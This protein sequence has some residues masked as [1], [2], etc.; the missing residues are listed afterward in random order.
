MSATDDGQESRS[1]K[2]KR[3]SGTIERE[4]GADVILICG[5]IEEDSAT[6]LEHE[7]SNECVNENVVV[8]L[9]TMGGSPDAAYRMTRNIQ[10][11]YK[12]GT[13]TLFVHSY[14]KSA[15]TLIA[16]GADEII[17]SNGAQLGPLDV[18]VAKPDELAEFTSG[19]TPKEAL[20]T[21]ESHAYQTFERFF[22]NLQVRSSGRITT[23]TAAE[24]ATNLAAGLF[25]PVYEQLDPMRLGEIERTNQIGYQ[26]GSRVETENVKKDTVGQLIA[27]YPSHRFVI[28]RAEAEE[29]F[30]NVRA[31]FAYEQELA[32]ALAPVIKQ[33]GDEP[34]VLQIPPKR[35]SEE[36]EDE[37]EDE[38]DGDE[39]NDGANTEKEPKYAT[40]TQSRQVLSETTSGNGSSSTDCSPEDEESSTGSAEDVSNGGPREDEQNS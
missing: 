26:Y 37:E 8:M 31:P 38:E 28:D 21:L 11:M 9:T 15:G 10:W 2:I 17:M 34:T 12:E 18:Q 23:K 24:I 36:E 29:L 19:L 1:E 16:L 14:C 6:K 7:L 40:G 27:G 30:N 32:T 3:L 25:A 35:E 20:S 5:E 33:Q 39:N 4:S 22:L 13:F